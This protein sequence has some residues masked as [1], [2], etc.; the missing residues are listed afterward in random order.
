MKKKIPIFLALTSLVKFVAP[1]LQKDEWTDLNN[2]LKDK[3][4]AVNFHLNRA[5]NP[6]DIFILGDQA[7]IVI[8]DFLLDNPEVF[9]ATDT[10]K[11]SKFVKHVPKSLEAAVKLKKQLKRIANGPNATESDRKSFRLALRAVSDL[12]KAQH[13]LELAKT[14]KHQ[15]NLYFKNKWEFAKN[16]VNGNLD[17][18]PEP[19]NFIKEKADEYYQ[20]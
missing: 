11:V 1:K 13:R 16:A 17:V 10:G 4:T 7:N 19:P 6:D 14:T 18:K 2:Q 20:L 9:E 15:E 5:T 8:R 3:L 12:K